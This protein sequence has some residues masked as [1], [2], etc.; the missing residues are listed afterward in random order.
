MLKKRLLVVIVLIPSFV[1]LL[2]RGDFGFVLIVTI[3]FGIAAWE[4]WHIFKIGGYNPSK[5][6]LVAG[7]VALALTRGIWGLPAS[8]FVLGVACMI[9]MARHVIGYERGEDRPGVNFAITAAGVF[10]LGWLGSYLLSVRALPDGE[11]WLMIVLPAIWIADG[12]AYFIGSLMGRHKMSPVTS[13]KKSWEGYIGGIV[14][15][16][17]FSALFAAAW[18]LRA[19]SVT[20]LRGLVM[21]L[22]LS[23]L[24]PMGDLG[25]SMLKRQF[26]VKDSSNIL[27]GHGGMLDRVDSWIWSGVIGYYLV[28]YLW[29]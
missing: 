29:M 6:V 19:P 2:D 8:E 12:G 16:L 23:V 5:I 28:V 22:V 4:Y 1:Y 15:C 26:G 11:W 20:P 17:V 27:P 21:G 24:S 7:V 3:M 10:Y 14:F 9:A 18:H 13:P 25:E